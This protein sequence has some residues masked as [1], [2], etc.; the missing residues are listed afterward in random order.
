MCQ[1]D[2]LRRLKCERDIVKRALANLPKTLD[3]T[4]DRIFLTIPDEEHLFVYHAFQ[5]IKYHNDL[6][7]GANIPC[8]VLLEAVG[9]STAAV[10]ANQIECFYD[11]ETLRE[12]CGCLIN[13]TPEEYSYG[14]IET[15]TVSF[16]HYTVREYLDSARISEHSTV[17]TTA[18][19]GNLKQDFMKITL[20]E[21]HH[22]KQNK[23]L[24]EGTDS[25]DTS[26]AIHAANDFNAYC[27]VSALLSITKWPSEISQHNVLCT[28]A[29]DLLDP[30][31]P[32]FQLLSA[33]ARHFS[34]E[35]P[36]YDFE[37]DAPFWQI[38]WNSDPGDNDA[39]HFLNISIISI[40]S[41]KYWESE[42]LALA[43]KFL[44][45]KDSYNFLQTRL[46][47]SARFWNM[48][49]SQDGG[50]GIDI[51]FDGSIIEFFAQKASQNQMTFKLLLEY[52]TGLF[53][54]SR[55][56]LFFIGHH[57]HGFFDCCDEYCMVKRLLK[58]GADPNE[59]EYRVTPLQI[60]V[61]S[62][63]S[64]GVGLLMKAGAD[65]N[66]SGNTNGIIWR[67]KT[68]MHQFSYL[69]G[70]SPLHI[71]RFFDFNGDDW[72]PEKDIPIRQNI[73]AILLQYGAEAILS[74]PEYDS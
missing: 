45:G 70:Y 11:Q 55:I 48:L 31:K 16:A 20:F 23:L 13:I 62:G 12:L 56:L 64:E 34:N 8:S 44:Q 3:E 69:H 19:K 17:Y 68:P 4:Y 14:R 71:C 36:E 15:L 25:I 65:P 26:N 42:C 33:T 59:T 18:C 43:R 39:V 72:P 61:I 22:V 28:L 6:Y 41:C 46:N 60:A 47:F 58:L 30:S 38:E 27:V 7:D 40:H 9:K 73:E 53:D 21:A 57:D 32:N 66:D 10:T 35:F 5:W 24:E 1:I 54:P 29:I 67:D 2:A 50:G 37:F 63:D 74:S 51:Y 49:S 52:G